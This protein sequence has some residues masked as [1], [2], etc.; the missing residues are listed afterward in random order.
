MDELKDL[1]RLFLINYG[2]EIKN[3]VWL[4]SLLFILKDRLFYGVEIIKYYD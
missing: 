3:E 4:E 1:I 2:I